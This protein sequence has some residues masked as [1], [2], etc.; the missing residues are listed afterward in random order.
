VHLRHLS[1]GNDTV[2]RELTRDDGLNA[3]WGGSFYAC[4]GGGWVKH[5][6]FMLDHIFAEGHPA[7]RFAD[8]S[9]LADDDIV[10]TV[11]AIGAPAAPN[12]D[13]QPGDYAR[14]LELVMERV[15]ERMGRTVAAVMTGQNG[16]ST[17]FNGWIQSSRL[18]VLALDAAGDVRAHPTGK[19]GGMGLTER[20]GYTTIQ[21]SYGANRRYTGGAPLEIVVVGNVIPTSDMLRFAASLPSGF[22]ATARN[23]VEAS[24][25][26]KS[27]A[28]GAITRALELGA[29]MRAASQSGTADDALR[30][31]LA[32]TGG[33]VIVR[34][35]VTIP[36]GMHQRGGF[37]HGVIVV[38][39]YR[40]H[41]LNE[42]MAVDD[43][44][45]QR[46]S[47]YPD[48]IGTLSAKSGRPVSVPDIQGMQPGTEIVV[49]QVPKELV[50]PARSTVDRY[51]LDEV[52]RIMGIEITTPALTPNVVAR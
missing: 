28:I 46:I 35:P 30:A 41:T 49:V 22:I 44:G 20:E 4:G 9:E 23:P 11:T 40:V 6:Q 45:G 5:G 26:K 51:A 1:E 18:G 13:I 48:V 32:T 24:W 17:T 21:A 12:S 43:P 42:Y 2:A 50:P 15:Q 31:I 29:A 10:V 8:V 52:E 14:A 37:D 34:G 19:L 25:V 7:P 38:D 36:D 39:G 16:S 27:A 33:R 47:T 3:I